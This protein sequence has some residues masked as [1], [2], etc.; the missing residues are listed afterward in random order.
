M[1]S[2]KLIGP[3]TTLSQGMSDSAW[4]QVSDRLCLCTSKTTA[5][6]KV[7]PSCPRCCFAV[8]GVYNRLAQ[9]HSPSCPRCLVRHWSFGHFSRCVIGSGAVV[10][11]HEDLVVVD[12]EQQYWPYLWPAAWSPWAMWVH[13]VLT[14]QD[15]GPASQGQKHN[16]PCTSTKQASVPNQRS[17]LS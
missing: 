5:H 14:L 12:L 4:T 1:T 16:M 9:E 6:G 10:S 2:D 7:R 15:A 13:V 3:Y 8:V 17:W 11:E